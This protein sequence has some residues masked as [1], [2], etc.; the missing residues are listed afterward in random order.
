MQKEI[1]ILN[2]LITNSEYRNSVFHYLKPEYFNQN[3][4][5]KLL[6]EHISSY[7]EKY[8][9]SPSKEA[10]IIAL[11][12]K[13]SIWDEDTL[14]TIFSI[15]EEIFTPSFQELQWLVDLTE[16]FCKTQAIYLGLLKSIEIHSGSVKNQTVE[17]IPDILREALA[18]S[19]DSRIALNYLDDIKERYEF[20]KSTETGIPFDLKALNK[21]TN[22]IGIPRKGITI[23]MSDT[24]AG[25]TLFKCHVA[26]SA[27]KQG[28]NV[29][30]IT[31]EMSR[32]RIAQRIDAN[33]LDTELDSIASLSE[34][35][36]IKSM[37]KV[38]KTCK[39]KLFIEEFPTS[40]GHSGH[41]RHLIEELKNKKNVDI[42]LLIVDY[43]NICA[44]VKHS[45][46]FGGT[47]MP[48]KSV[49][50]ELRALGMEYNC[51]VLSSTQS[52]REGLGDKDRGFKA[53][54]ESMGI[55]HTADILW[56][57]FRN[58]SLDEVNKI[59]FVQ[60]KN[61]LKDLT[62]MRRFMVGVDRPK[63]KLYDVSEDD[64][65]EYI[66]HPKERE[67]HIQITANQFKGRSDSPISFSDFK[68]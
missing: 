34:D 67:D 33:L 59:L 24:H 68:F 17:E 29:L 63:M 66:T 28:Y 20:Y 23:L 61:R 21:A 39:G 9:V 51:A 14:K 2:Q 22:S 8:K 43:I 5:H 15:I 16:E 12:N 18:I 62:Q 25:K 27:L 41:F 60:L 42:D 55:A 30:Y 36:Y 37:Q 11:K 19:F 10:L 13:I 38:I 3:T 35:V 40:V 6:F 46:S 44:S 26:A 1:M 45:S 7:I 48:V 64:L 58:E 65:A 4:L 32:E 53:V 47:Y 57:L 49:A 54:A 56:S 31:L 50:E 52:N